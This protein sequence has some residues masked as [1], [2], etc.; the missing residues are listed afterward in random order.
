MAYITYKLRWVYRNGVKILQEYIKEVDQ[1]S[2]SN[3][4]RDVPTVIGDNMWDE[5]GAEE[6]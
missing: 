4:W 5:D 1:T 3:Y 6:E 2:V